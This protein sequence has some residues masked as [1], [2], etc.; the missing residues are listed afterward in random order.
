MILACFLLI[1][2][3]STIDAALISSPFSRDVPVLQ[4][5]ASMV[6]TPNTAPTNPAE[7]RIKKA[8][9]TFS[10]DHPQTDGLFSAA[11]RFFRNR[12]LLWLPGKTETDPITGIH[13]PNLHS[14]PPPSQ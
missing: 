14:R 6:L 11:A 12:I 7:F 8:G 2:F 3:S 4:H 1:S 10:A 9:Q 5:G 13:S